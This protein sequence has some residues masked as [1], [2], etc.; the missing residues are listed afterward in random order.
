MLAKFSPLERG[1]SRKES[2]LTPSAYTNRNTESKGG[3]LPTAWKA[4]GVFA[5]AILSAVII[6]SI[7]YYEK[8]K[9]ISKH[10]HMIKTAWERV[11]DMPVLTPDKASDTK[12]R[13]RKPTGS[14]KDNEGEPSGSGKRGG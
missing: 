14:P 9:E 4:I 13:E 10:H 6:L 8:T 1:Q 5:A 3:F 2:A 12:G 11:A 7:V